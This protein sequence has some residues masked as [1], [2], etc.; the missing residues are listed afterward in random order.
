MTPPRVCPICASAEV[1]K[2]YRQRFSE[3][4]DGGLFDGYDIVID[5]QC[6][7]VFQMISTLDQNSTDTA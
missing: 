1:D 3:F 7:L 2:I 5:K 4:S 6:G